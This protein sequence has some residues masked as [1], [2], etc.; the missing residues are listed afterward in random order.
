MM[1]NVDEVRREL[2]CYPLV[3]DLDRVA[4]GAVRVETCFVYPDGASVDVF[5]GHRPNLGPEEAPPYSVT[6]GGQTIAWLL[7]VQVKPWLSKK[8]QA[9]VD[10]ALRLYGVRQEG[11]VL[12]CDLAGLSGLSDAVVRLG[13]ACVRVADLNYTRRASLQ[14]VFHEEVEEILADGDVPYEPNVEL[15][16]RFGNVVRVDFLAA[17]RRS[18]SAVLGLS[19]GN[20]SQAHVQAVEIF[21]RWYDLDVPERDEQRVTV[22]DDRQDVYRDDDL[23]RLE[24]ISAMIPLSDR[25]G[26]IEL[27]AA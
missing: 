17:G 11:A 24:Q 15:E 20:R 22:W 8:R 14:T 25:E 10:D 26:L 6:D 21:K 19:S 23:Q 5:V 1:V 16:G 13:Q 9:F 27:V 7:D 2:A 18:R 3:R 4:S 12:A